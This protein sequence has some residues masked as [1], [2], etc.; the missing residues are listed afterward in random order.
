MGLES[1]IMNGVLLTMAVL[2]MDSAADCPHS[3]MTECRP[4]KKM[5]SKP[6]ILSGVNGPC[7]LNKY[8]AG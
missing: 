4:V 8:D 2:R 5:I 1:K 3:V 6:G 7:C